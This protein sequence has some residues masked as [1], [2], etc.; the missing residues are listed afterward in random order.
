MQEV[1]DAVGAIG[2]N[3]PDSLQSGAVFEN[4]RSYVMWG[5]GAM[6]DR[7]GVAADEHDPARLAAIAARAVAGWAP[8]FRT[9]VALADPTTLSQFAIR[10]STVVGP[11][12][13]GRVTLIGDA[14]HAMT[15]YRG[16]GANMALEDAVRLKRAI[17]AGAR[18][19]RDLFAAIGAYE[20]EMRDYGFRAARNS[21]KAMRQSVDAGALSLTA[22]RLM[23]RTIDRLPP[24]KRWMASRMGRD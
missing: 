20:S 22:Q 5:V 4:T 18:R 2:T 15:P 11:W 1:N 10:T 12:P 8:E 13:T 9:L 21:L 19:E 6:R 14:I 23:L 16:I 24:V 17:V 7:L 3:E